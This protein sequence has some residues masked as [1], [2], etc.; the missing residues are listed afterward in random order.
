MEIHEAGRV[1]RG[2]VDMVGGQKGHEGVLE[3]SMNKY[4]PYL[5]VWN[6]LK[7]SSSI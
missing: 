3:G 2:W 4:P 7:A 6:H 1:P 5:S